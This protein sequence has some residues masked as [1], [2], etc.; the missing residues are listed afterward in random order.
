[1][2]HLEPLSK[3]CN[4]LLATKIGTNFLVCKKCEDEF[5]VIQEWK[6][7]SELSSIVHK[8]KNTQDRFQQ[9]YWIGFIGGMRYTRQLAGV[10]R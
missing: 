9:N 3:C 10:R 4:D 5:F 7:Q 1:M 6:I 8:M 2:D